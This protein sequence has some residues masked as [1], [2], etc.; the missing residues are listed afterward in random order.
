MF[1]YS[2]KGVSSLEY[3]SSY[4]PLLL[5]Y[6]SWPEW[7][8]KRESFLYYMDSP[9]LEMVLCKDDP[10]NP[11]SHWI[12]LLYTVTV[13]MVKNILVRWWNTKMY[14]SPWVYLQRTAMVSFFFFK[15]WLSATQVTF[16][17]SLC[18]E[19]PVYTSQLVL[20]L[21]LS[22]WNFPESLSLGRSGNYILT[23]WDSL[24]FVIFQ[25]MFVRTS[26]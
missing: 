19:T 26:A 8:N 16:C 11:H 7:S 15:Y 25:E 2:Q 1:K 24:G 4:T 13:D 9:L 21:H 17:Q 3:T 18:K 5:C 23:T 20:L 6:I 22:I 10:K 12:Q 14:S